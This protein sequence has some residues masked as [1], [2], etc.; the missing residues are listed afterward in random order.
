MAL[1][2]TL[3][4]VVT[5][6]NHHHR[7]SHHPLD[8]IAT[9]S[10]LRLTV[11]Q[12]FQFLQAHRL[13]QLARTTRL[14]TVEAPLHSPHCQ[15]RITTHQHQASSPLN[16][17]SCPLP[18]TAQQ[19]ILDMSPLL[20]FRTASAA[21]LNN[22]STGPSQ[23]CRSLHQSFQVAYMLLTDPLYG[24]PNRRSQHHY[25]HHL[26]DRLNCNLLHPTF[27]ADTAPSS[28]HRSPFAHWRGST[29]AAP[30]TYGITMIIATEADV[31][32]NSVHTSFYIT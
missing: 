29:V 10:Q 6:R 14:W 19:I 3:F 5:P 20:L 28:H 11:R 32:M 16:S 13:K 22:I 18:G 26:Q 31:T 7:H 9:G 25:P 17:L 1:R 24:F 30:P 27:T 21:H 8:T 23:P 12:H 15:L 4:H 2:Q